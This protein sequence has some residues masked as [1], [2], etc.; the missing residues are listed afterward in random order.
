MILSHASSGLSIDLRENIVNTICVESPESFCKL[1]TDLKEDLDQG[2]RHYVLSDDQTELSM[3]KNAELIV[4]PWSIDINSRKI[5]AKLYGLL[6]DTANDYFFD[7][8]LELKSH[9][10]RYMEGLADHEPYP[11]S[12]DLDL[13]I[14][15]LLKAVDVRIETGTNS[16]E[17]KLVEY[18]KAVS[19]MCLIRLVFLVNFKS[20]LNPE[21]LKLLYKEAALNK[22]QLVLFENGYREF[23]TGEKTVII[24]NDRCVI[25]I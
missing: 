17:E 11:L 18:L 15:T 23:V 3:Q 12:Y 22:V 9:I 4:D 2:T 19:S 20:F 16:F 25:Q 10:F 6:T 8:F 1:I 13:D 14:G 24:D 7:S 21:K 5:K